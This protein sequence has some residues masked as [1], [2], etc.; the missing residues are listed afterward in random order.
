MVK[1][2]GLAITRINRDN[3]AFLDVIHSVFDFEPQEKRICLKG[4]TMADTKK[5]HSNDFIDELLS[6]K[7]FGRFNPSA[8]LTISRN[9][10]CLD[11][12]QLES[13]EKSFRRWAEKPVRADVRFSRKRILLVFLLIRYTGGKLKEI[14]NINVQDDIDDDKHLVRLGARAE[15]GKPERREVHIPPEVA[16]EIAQALQE[17]EIGVP[18]SSFF[19]IDPGHIRRKFYERAKEC[20]FPSEYGNPNA[21]RKSRAIELLRSNMPPVV[22]QRLLGLSTPGMTASV[23]D[24]SNSDMRR[25]VRHYVDKENRRKT[26]ARNTFLCKITGIRKGDIQAAIEMITLGGDPLFTVITNESLMRLGLKK[27][28]FVVAEVKAPWVILSRD[29]DPKASAENRFKGTVSR[30][31]RGKITSEVMVSLSDGTELC[32]IMSDDSGKRLNLVEGQEIWAMFNSF[33]VILNVD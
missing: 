21:I 33:A 19:Q 6:A 3:E 28:A 23:L 29:E 13:L 24:F 20:G 31:I 1:R 16:R 5:R 25:V 27:N 30:V 18:L 22:V 4:N 14:T 26:S 9:T 12:V 2:T 17:P 11:T 8:I 15:K 10:K 32:S 7:K